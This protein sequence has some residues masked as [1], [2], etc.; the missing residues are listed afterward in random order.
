MLRGIS[1]KK[2]VLA[3]ML[4]GVAAVAARAQIVQD[5]GPTLPGYCTGGPFTLTAGEVKFHVALDDQPD[6]LPMNV[7]LRIYDA[8]G[9]VV[10]RL[11]TP[12]AAGYTTTLEHRGAGLLRAQATFDSLV[13]PSSRRQTVGLVEVFDVDGF[14]AEI[15][16]QCRP[17]E[18]IAE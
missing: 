11:R 16:V 3:L 15:P 17:N 1:P 2:T 13:N 12:L 7:T 6:A 8:Q 18:R 14:R 10:A 4:A 5:P 9:S